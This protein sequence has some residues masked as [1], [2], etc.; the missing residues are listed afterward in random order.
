MES[1]HES[2][3]IAGAWVA[4]ACP[5][6]LM[7]LG[8]V[9]SAIC[10]RQPKRMGRVTERIAWVI[11]GLAVI[12]AVIVGVGG[13]VVH[14][15]VE[16]K[17]VGGF[18]LALGVYV[19]AVSV[20]MLLL[21]SFLGAIVM[22]YSR[23][24]LAGD[25]KQGRF[26]KWLCLTTGSVL[27][28]TIAGNLLVFA[29]AW[30][31]TSLCLHQLLIFYPEREAAQISARKKFFISRI[32][33]VC[34]ISASVLLYSVFGSLNFADLFAGAATVEPNAQWVGAV[35]LIV[36]GALLKSAQFPF[37]TWLPDT[38]ETP[39][40]VSALMHAGIINAGGYLIIRLSPLVAA[41]PSALNTLAIVGGLTALF[42]SVVMLTQT[43]VKR[44]LAYS[45]VAQMGFM[46]LQCG[47]G[48]FAIALLHIVAHSLYK[49]HAFLSSGSIV[50]QVRAS[51]LPAE[52]SR[53]HPAFLIG[54]LLLA[55]FGTLM[56]AVIFGV[57]PVD[58]PGV[59]V[60]GI[61]LMLGITHLLWNSWG[62]SQAV[63]V[64]G[65]ALAL[66]VSVAFF[67]LHELAVWVVGDAVVA[68]PAAGAVEYG[69][70][71]ALIAL[72]VG[73]LWFQAQLPYWGKR[74]W[75]RRIYVHLAN[76]L[77]LDA[78]AN[79]LVTSVWPVKRSN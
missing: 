24:Y 42:A 32:G 31:S 13:R 33:D 63:A 61:V 20:V 37:H 1:S 18:E 17:F 39:T 43:S 23:N 29:L 35:F 68:A 66:G 76:S 49:A 60:L 56:V 34:L 65:L 52:R 64:R 8:L 59:I 58:K 46:M 21:V 79:R 47:L 70:M 73:T 36:G 19:D 9:P 16:V 4:F 53:P 71:L 57:S 62:T 50:S 54:A 12:V 2:F 6:L 67:V 15:F 10:N 55:S 25:P 69:I 38:M 41:V 11:F 22:R 48:A 45:T 14:S 78:L 5:V 44:S 40:P 27:M 7:L 3:L 30:I 77:Y 72:F 28:L 26:F 51:W 74:P 75:V